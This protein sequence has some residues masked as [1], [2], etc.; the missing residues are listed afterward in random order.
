MTPCNDLTFFSRS[1]NTRYFHSVYIVSRLHLNNNSLHTYVMAVARKRQPPAHLRDEDFVLVQFTQDNK[2]L[3]VKESGLTV[4]GGVTTAVW[5]SDK[6]H[7]K[8]L[9]LG[10][11]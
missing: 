9:V 6:K 10:K 8:C 1:Y 5:P 11:S 7:Y 3:V 4:N 2:Y